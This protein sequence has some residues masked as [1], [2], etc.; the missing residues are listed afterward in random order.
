[1]GARV[2]AG[3]SPARHRH[4]GP[5]HAPRAR[6]ARHAPL[7]R[8]HADARQLRLGR[9][10]TPVPAQQARLSRAD[11]RVPR[12]AD[13][14]RAARVPAPPPPE[15]RRRCRAATFTALGI[16]SRVPVRRVKVVT[17]KRYIVKPGDSLIAIARRAHIS[18][19]RLVHMNKVDPSKALLIGTHLRLPA[20]RTAAPA[21]VSAT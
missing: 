13:R 17:V 9:R 4:R 5:A 20:P 21:S 6:A 1:R 8:A 12:R 10:R 16:Q 18:L 19:A 3:A 7:R 14:T 11:Q 2:P 15:R